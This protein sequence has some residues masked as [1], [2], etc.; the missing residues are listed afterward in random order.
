LPP[1]DVQEAEEHRWLAWIGTPIVVAAIF[2]AIAFATGEAWIL[3]FTVIVLIGD[4]FV[5][6]MLALT[7]DTNRNPAE[8]PTAHKTG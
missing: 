3:T 6:I 8:A 7:T 4:I 2:M 1:L 5:L